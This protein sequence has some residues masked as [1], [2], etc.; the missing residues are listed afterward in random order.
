MSFK[1]SL[2][3]GIFISKLTSKSSSSYTL[4]ASAQK[5]NDFNIANISSNEINSVNYCNLYM[6]NAK[7]LDSS[8][9]QHKIVNNKLPIYVPFYINNVTY[10]HWVYLDSPEIII[11]NNFFD[12]EEIHD[13]F[14][15]IY[16]KDDFKLCF[17]KVRKT[18]YCLERHE[19]PSPSGERPEEPS[20]LGN[21]TE[22]FNTILIEDFISQNQK[23]IIKDEFYNS[24]AEGVNSIKIH[25]INKNESK[26]SSDKIDSYKLCILHFINKKVGW[27]SPKT[28]TTVKFMG[29]N[30]RVFPN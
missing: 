27:L 23:N 15:N 2:P 16:S 6:K 7:N 26:D 9:N 13:N 8:E 25:I 29:I 19:E 14:Y 30:M 18:E 1:F 5:S 12:F 21:S 28:V 4:C 10:P 17:D 20:P 22:S 11:E 3:S 24:S